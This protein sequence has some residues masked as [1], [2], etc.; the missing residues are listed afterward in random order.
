MASGVA[1]GL[2]ACG[3]DRVARAPLEA[4]APAPEGTR[5]LRVGPARVLVHLGDVPA[6]GEAAVLAWI[7]DAA[8]QVAGYYGELPV[9]DVRVELRLGGRGIHASTRAEGASARVDVTVAAGADAAQLE[10]DWV[11]AHELA[12]LG[13]PAVPRAQHWSEEGLAT[14]VEPVARVRA[15][16]LSEERFWSELVRFLPTGQPRAGDRG[17]DRTPTWART[18][19][20]GA[21]FWFVADV[22][23]RRRTDGRLGL[24][25]AL[26]GLHAA[27]GIMTRR[28]SL[29]E[30]LAAADRAVGV[31]VLVELHAAWR[32]DPVAVDL[33]ELWRLLGVIP[34]RRGVTLD[35]DAPWAALRRG[36]TA[37]Q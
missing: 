14:Y 12:H 28:W 8:R 27:G 21:L 18:Y 35:D 36:I 33:D 22:E 16:D 6:A 32:H 24:E 37:P 1:G 20:G 5:A 4:E 29:E 11:M 10:D 9:R 2:V 31:P 26:R 15:G 34:G 19:W 13:F 25:H 30:A 17:L 3:A 23:I 7:E